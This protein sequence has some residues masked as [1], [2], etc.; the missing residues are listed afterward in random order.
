MLLGT[1]FLSLLIFLY[2]FRNKFFTK[3]DV[4]PLIAHELK[5]SITSLSGFSEILLNETLSK[6]QKQLALFQIQNTSTR[7]HAIIESILL[8]EKK[9]P[10][11]KVNLSLFLEKLKK[12]FEKKHNTELVIQKDPNLQDVVIHQ[13]LFSLALLNLLENSIKYGKA[14]ITLHV[15]DN[16]K[17]VQFSVHDTGN[18]LLQKD[19]FSKGTCTSG[20]NGLGLYLVKKIIEKHKGSISAKSSKEKG[21]VFKLT[22]SKTC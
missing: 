16:K 11:K 18:I 10:L 13:D 15:K 12:E 1:L 14:P 7:M 20:G 19:L 5:S 3:K 22:L 2:L 4:T 6:E 17:K 21:T 9:L 8:L